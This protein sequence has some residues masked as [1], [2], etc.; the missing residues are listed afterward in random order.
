MSCSNRPTG[1]GGTSISHD[2]TNS[3]GRAGLHLTVWMELGTATACCHVHF[4]YR[5]KI[6][7][8]KKKNQSSKMKRASKNRAPQYHRPRGSFRD[9]RTDL[10]CCRF[11]QRVSSACWE[12]VQTR[13]CSAAGFCQRSAPFYETSEDSQTSTQHWCECEQCATPFDANAPSKNIP[14]ADNRKQWKQWAKYSESR[15]RLCSEC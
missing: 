3:T 5:D 13:F 7:N 4:N 14:R 6:S 9:S 11:C 10:Q 8:H 15:I 1:G 2:S 12:T